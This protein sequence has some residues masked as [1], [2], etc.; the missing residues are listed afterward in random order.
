M[1]SSIDEGQF[2]VELGRNLTLSTVVFGIFVA[3]GKLIY[4]RH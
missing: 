2:S 4:R 3:G 1:A